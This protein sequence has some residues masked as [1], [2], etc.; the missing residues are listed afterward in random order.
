MVGHL[1]RAARLAHRWAVAADSYV[2]GV[3][4]LI[5]RTASHPNP[6]HRLP[7][8]AAWPG[9]ISPQAW[10]R[11]PPGAGETGQGRAP[12]PGAVREKGREGTAMGGRGRPG[13]RGGG[14]ATLGRRAQ[15]KVHFQADPILDAQ[16]P[17]DTGLG[18][19]EDRKRAGDPVCRRHRHHFRG[20]SNSSMGL[21]AGSSRRICLPPK[22]V[23]MS[24]RNRAP[25]LRSVST[26][27]ARSRTSS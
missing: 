27:R 15:G 8:C 2:R 7:R 23:T 1:V 18:Q 9:S 14:G 22:P 19:R 10:N 12:I 16:G 3:S 11:C 21:P 5:S 26:S 4:L 24:L 17:E 20:G 6:L 13:D 25:A